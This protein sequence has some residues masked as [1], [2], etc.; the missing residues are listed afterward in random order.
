M[1]LSPKQIEEVVDR[2]LAE[3]LGLGDATTEAIIP[4]GLHARGSIVARQ[5]GILAGTQIVA[6]VFLRVDP[7]LHVDLLLQDGTRLA[8]GTEV[9]R[10]EG[11]AT[12]IL[13]A[14]R[15]ALNF[16]QHLSGIATVTSSYV[17]AVSGL[18]VR[19]VDTRKTTPGLRLLEKYAVTVG[20]GHNHRLNLADGILIKDNHLAALA[21]AGMTL[22]DAVARAMQNAP[23]SLNVE[24]EVDT[25]EQAEEALA[26]GAGILLLDNMS[27]E[28]MRHV[29]EMARGRAVIEASGGITVDRVRAVAEVGVD[30][31][32]VGALTHS[33]PA[34]YLALDFEVV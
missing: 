3:D 4:P 11:E 30:L 7:S 20:G 1:R 22:D 16:L 14:E 2:A 31:I 21:A 33:V 10:V 8:P 19:I 32:S 34:L 27:L 6:A 15:T 12:S 18:P 28:D 29:I 9:V 23:H 24:V 26:A 13:K 17:E 5:P 25:L